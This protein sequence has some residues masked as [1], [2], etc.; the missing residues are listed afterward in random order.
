ML[1]AF[2]FE[3]AW[4]FSCGVF[5][6]HCNR[7]HLT[8]SGFDGDS[9][10]GEDE[11]RSSVHFLPV[12]LDMS[13]GNELLGSE[14]GRGKAKAVD[15][16]IEAALEHFKEK[17]CCVAFAEERFAVGIDKLLLADHAVDGFQLLALFELH[18]KVRFFLTF[19]AVHSGG[20]LF[21]EHRVTCF[22]ENI[23]SELTGNSVFGSCISSHSFSNRLKRRQV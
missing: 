1:L 19:C 2:E 5:L 17:L 22:A 16:I 8:G 13:V 6:R 3:I 12:D 4:D 21:M 23:R 14:D 10:A 20:I 15:E 9:H 7:F 11:E 18:A